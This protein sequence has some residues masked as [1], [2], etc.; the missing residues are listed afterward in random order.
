MRMRTVVV[1][2]ML[3]TI[4][5]TGTLAGPTF[6]QES[7]VWLEDLTA[8]ELK[9]AVDAGKTVAIFYGSGT[10]EGGAEVVLGKHLFFV[11]ALAERTA[12]ELGNAIVLPISP[13]APGFPGG[14]PMKRRGTWSGT[15]TISDDTWARMT[16]DIITSA[17]VGTG[18]KY[19]AV[20][21]DHGYPQDGNST[22]GNFDGGRMKRL[23]EELDAEWKP[24][25]THVFYVPTYLEHD[26]GVMRDT[27]LKLGIPP[28]LLAKADDVSEAMYLEP[29]PGQW[30][31]L[32][33]V[34]PKVKAVSSKALGKQ[35]VDF[36]IASVVRH[37][38]AQMASTKP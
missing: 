5:F 28:N 10:H 36:K 12:R 27:Y 2:V 25:G 9:A 33:K 26:E 3:V 6:A 20:L 22:G 19:V 17:I 21:G 30:V 14:D 7:S 23:A 38:R 24:K 31:R 35:S 32:D 34:D 8:V 18:F 29:A 15:L 37:V 11:R 16:K 1:G 4:A 13:Y